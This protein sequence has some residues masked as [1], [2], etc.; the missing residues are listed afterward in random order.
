MRF[1]VGAA[2]DLPAGPFD[3]VMERHVVWTL[4]E[5]VATLRHWRQVAGRLVL[6]EGLWG[7]TDPLRRAAD[8]AADAARRLMRTPPDHHA[9]YP[10]DVFAHLP[11]A[12]Q[13]SPGPMIEA[14]F[15][16]GW[17]GARIKRLRDVEWAARL[18]EPWPLGWLE[19]RPRYA[20]VAEA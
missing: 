8:R 19:Q 16:A 9:P 4:P 15:D 14:V 12:R 1:V 17:T 13:S 11:L 3:A 5:P 18:H 7:R 2:S 20:L 10:E 6:F